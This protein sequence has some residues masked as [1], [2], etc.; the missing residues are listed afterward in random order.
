VKLAAARLAKMS[1]EIRAGLTDL[2]IELFAKTWFLF[3]AVLGIWLA[4]LFLVL[5]DLVREVVRVAVTIGVFIQVGIWG[6]HAA[7]ELI[8]F[9]LHKRADAKGEQVFV[10]LISTLTAIA[11][12]S[13]VVMLALENLGVDVTGLIAASAVATIG[14]SMA[15]KDLFSDLF[16]SLSIALDKPFQVGDYIV[17][18]DYMG[19]VE[20]IG[21]KS[22][23]IRSLTGELLIIANHDLLS[24]RIRSY[25]GM[26]ARRASFGF[27]V[28]YDTPADKLA[29]IPAWIRE[30]IESEESTRFDR[31]HFTGFGDSSLDFET[32]FYM[33]VP[34]YA[35]YRDVQQRVNIALCRKLEEEGV[36][37]AF[38]TRTVHVETDGGDSSK[39]VARPARKKPATKKKPTRKKKSS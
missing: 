7:R 28:T 17:V 27:G 39:K 37:F 26:T 18:G 23:R 2:P 16:A 35:T 6:V 19:T 36:E 12:W 30:A 29:E 21:L 38:P 8:L 22:S 3:Y 32:V 11:V 25:K 13:L 24:S 15:A 10:G 4:S 34:D 20:R 1:E 31:A 9:A 14:I 5:P 33:E